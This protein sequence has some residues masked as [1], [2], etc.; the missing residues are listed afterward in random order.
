MAEDIQAATLVAGSFAQPEDG[1]EIEFHGDSRTGLKFSKRKNEGRSFLLV[2]STE[3]DSQVAKLEA[4]EGVEL[5]EF[6]KDLQLVVSEVN[7]TV[8]RVED[9]FVASQVEQKIIGDTRPV[10]VFLETKSNY[11]LRL[12][13]AGDG[14][15]VEDGRGSDVADNDETAVDDSDFQGE[16]VRAID[17]Y[18]A[19]QDGDLSFRKDDLIWVTSKAD[20]AWWEGFVYVEGDESDPPSLTFPSNYVEPEGDSSDVEQSGRESGQE[21]GRESGRESRRES[22]NE[23]GRESNKGSGRQGSTPEEQKS[24]GGIGA[25]VLSA[26]GFGRSAE[27]KADAQ[28]DHRDAEKT[29][30]SAA[31]QQRADSGS[32]SGNDKPTRDTGG[33]RSPARSNSQQSARAAESSSDD[34]SEPKAESRHAA[35]TNRTSSRT[36]ASSAEANKPIKAD[37]GP[38]VTNPN[39]TDKPCND[40]RI[41]TAGEF[42]MCVCGW[43][44][45]EH[46]WEQ[47]KE[48]RDN[49]EG[50]QQ[51]HRLRGRASQSEL[52]PSASERPANSPPPS[53]VADSSPE[54]DRPDQH[55]GR[56]SPSYQP[57]QPGSP[58]SPQKVSRSPARRRRSLPS[59]SPRLAAAPA[60]ATTP[61]ARRCDHCHPPIQL[62]PSLAPLH[63]RPN[64][65]HQASCTA[66]QC[67][68]R[69]ACVRACACCPSRDDPTDA[70]AALRRGALV[71]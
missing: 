18:E 32:E 33:R 44:K 5:R 30:R 61:P 42:G 41:D 29:D 59:P 35:A 71:Q 13:S 6:E 20:P 17:D 43:S 52:S 60:A 53:S 12:E 45:R 4:T 47:Q 65:R 19:Q 54:R 34:A 1:L 51:K 37:A 22:G 15:A 11:F 40:Y 25:G 66:C 28:P 56:R 58:S 10:R 7:G 49:L 14:E 3:K 48:I 23:S 64:H 24:S 2:V 21:S 57:T 46:E 68:L 31:S 16:Y 39:R 70:S 8:V 9:N 63:P 38:A 55:R 27:A 62:T 69:R 36:Q 50:L 67:Q 26:F